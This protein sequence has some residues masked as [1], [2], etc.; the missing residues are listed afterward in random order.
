MLTYSKSWRSI[1]SRTGSLYSRARTK[2]AS[3]FRQQ[4]E[5]WLVTSDFNTDVEGQ[6]SVHKGER[7]E[8]L[9][10]QPTEGADWVQVAVCEEPK[11]TGLVP[12]SIL[13]PG[14]RSV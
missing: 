11:R 12:L 2:L 3:S 9:E 10:Q 14:V 4:P 1:R 8:V 5:Q 7:V 6:L 13:L